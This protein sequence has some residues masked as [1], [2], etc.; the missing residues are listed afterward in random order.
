MLTHNADLNGEVI[1]LGAH[2]T[3][4]TADLFTHKLNWLGQNNN[5]FKKS[6]SPGIVAIKGRC[7]KVPIVTAQLNLNST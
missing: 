5:S 2:A 3:F 4:Q 1:I 6:E 7:L